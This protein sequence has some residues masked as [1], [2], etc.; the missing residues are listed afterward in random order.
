MAFLPR[1]KYNFIAYRSSKVS[2]SR[3]CILKIH[4]LW[5]SGFSRVYSNC[6]CSCWFAP[7]IIK[8]GQSSHNM[9]SNI[10]VNFQESTTILN[11]CT[12]KSGN[13]FNAQRIIYLI[14][15]CCTF[16]CVALKSFTEWGNIQRVTT[17]STNI[18]PSTAGTSHGLNLVDHM[19]YA[20][21]TNTSQNMGKLLTHPFSTRMS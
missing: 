19:I 1:K 8:I 7:E 15:L 12:K 20:L 16:I 3:D 5:Q 18:L 21:K 10:T 6:C 13:L 17:L 4:Q 14:K 2:W 9:Y 11:G